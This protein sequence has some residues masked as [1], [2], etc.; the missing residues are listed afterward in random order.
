MLQIEDWNQIKNCYTRNTSKQCT[1]F[2]QFWEFLKLNLELDFFRRVWGGGGGGWLLPRVAVSM[3]GNPY[4]WCNL[5]IGTKLKTVA[6]EM[7]VSNVQSGKENSSVW[8]C[9][10]SFTLGFGFNI[11]GGVDHPHVGS[12]PGIFITTVRADSTA[13]IDGRL[14]PGDRI[15][16][17]S[18]H[19]IGG[20]SFSF[21]DLQV[22]KRDACNGNVK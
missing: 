9:S 20:V 6:L 2:K 22:Q 15:L 1:K 16:A 11:R 4:K 13:G 18:V 8:L 10:F 5:R 21:D 12:D 3:G 14:E 17:V 19:Q 7:L